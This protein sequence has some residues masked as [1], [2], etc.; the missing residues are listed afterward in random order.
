M[1]LTTLACALCGGGL[2]PARGVRARWRLL[3][4]E[5]CA[6]V[7]APAALT[8]AAEADA[9][10]RAHFGDAFAAADDG[11]TRWLD[12][13]NARRMRRLLGRSLAAGAR[14]LE[15]GPGHGGLLAAL[16]AAG[17]RVR[18]LELSPA[19]AEATR[20]RSGVP[21]DVG[22]VERHAA[23]AS[24]VYDAVVARHVLEHMTDPAA[25]VQAMWAV[26]APRGM[27]YVAVPNVD[28]PE[29][30]LP[31]WSGYQSYHL[32]YFRPDGL[33]RLVQRT[34]LEIV[35]LR[36]REPFSGWV[37][38]VVNSLR[39]PGSGTPAPDGVRPGG[40]VVGAY[41]VARLVAGTLLAPAR[42]VQAWSGLGEEIELVARRRAAS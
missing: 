9:L 10:Q 34:G 11:W 13:A 23:Q 28:A 25:A 38:A 42:A 20:R 2:H 7:M 35:R 26:L 3:A 18:G 14:V 29:A 19:V 36:T 6:H 33:R 41:N 15:I 24:G 17:F 4:C 1:M 32:H 30:A 31:G 22:T 12:R 39:G 5:A 27:L 16:A 21:V 37:N 40:V 8:P